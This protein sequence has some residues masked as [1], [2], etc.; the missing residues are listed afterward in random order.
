MQKIPDIWYI[1]STNTICEDNK[2][3]RKFVQY[4]KLSRQ[5]TKLIMT[6]QT[7]TTKYQGHVTK[8]SSFLDFSKGK[9][10]FREV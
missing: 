6:L 4:L 1:I 9:I 5:I 3:M 2:S 10:H 7:Y 8:F